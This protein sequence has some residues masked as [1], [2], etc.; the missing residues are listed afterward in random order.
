M[1]AQDNTEAEMKPQHTADRQESTKH[2][3]AHL[4]NKAWTD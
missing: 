1:T 3:A 4:M 2:P